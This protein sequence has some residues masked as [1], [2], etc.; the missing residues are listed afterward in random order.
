MKL[1]R[2]ALT[3]LMLWSLGL[4]SAMAQQSLRSANGQ[5]VRDQYGNQVDPSTQPDSLETN[6][7]VEAPPP[8]LY[9]WHLD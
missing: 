7:S 5:T 3:Y 8:R 2:I 1:I 9:M 6:S 4:M